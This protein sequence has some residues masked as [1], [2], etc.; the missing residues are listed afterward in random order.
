MDLDKLIMTMIGLCVTLAFQAV[1]QLVIA[2]KKPNGAHAAKELIEAVAQLQQQG[3]KDMQTAYPPEKFNRMHDRV[4]Q[5]H[6][7]VVTGDRKGAVP[8]IQIRK[9][10]GPA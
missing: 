5:L 4:I 7:V 1:V 6:E 2:S 3:Q 8:Q 10:E 9:A